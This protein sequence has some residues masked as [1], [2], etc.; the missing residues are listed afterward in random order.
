MA[1]IIILKE[2][3]KLNIEQR[4]IGPFEHYPEDEFAA[5]HEGED[6][7]HRYIQELEPPASLHRPA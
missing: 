6:W 4:F 2:K 3:G 5:T 7:E 1:W